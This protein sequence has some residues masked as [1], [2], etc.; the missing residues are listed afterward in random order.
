MSPGKHPRGIILLSALAIAFI[1]ALWVAA[2]VQRTTMQSSS[3]VFSHKK[4]R[5]Y[6]LART[7]ISRSLYSINISP[8][9]VNNHNSREQADS[10]TT[11]GAE[12]WVET[13]GGQLLLRCVAEVDRQTAKLDVP[14]LAID[15]GEPR[16][17]AVSPSLGSGPDVIA[18]TG[19]NT[20]GWHSLPPIPGQTEILDICGGEGAATFA[21]ATDGSVSTVWRYRP[22]RGWM[23]LPDFPPGVTLSSIAVGS[24]SRLL[25]LGSDNS[26][27]VLPLNSSLE[28]EQVE[29]PS[30]ADLS[31]IAPSIA[32]QPLAYVTAETSGSPSVYQLNLTSNHWSQIPVPSAVQ[33]DAEGQ[34]QATG[35]AVPN[36]EGGIAADEQ[37]NIF[38]ASNP[39][40]E[41]A[42]LYRFEPELP[43]ASTGTW[44]A[45]PA[46]PHFEWDPDT[47]IQ[48]HGF[49]QRFADLKADTEGH[50]WVRSEGLPPS[51]PSNLLIDINGL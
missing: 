2:A 36:F 38:V 33:H 6:Y 7:G 41:S 18:W 21:L 31:A 47:G 23:Q 22:G 12:C 45:F 14:L 49:A 17:L 1:M 25:G 28:W 4:S 43:G 50:L 46:I 9:W 11:E 34:P 24:G 48:G 26:L 3:V 5:A 29:A 30:G 51:S 13:I 10:T 16:V 8:H 27:V 35:G 32:N 42:V 19:V 39:P 15:T 44:Q 40:G 20:E 37:G